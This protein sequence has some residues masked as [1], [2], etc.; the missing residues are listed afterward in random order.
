MNPIVP[1]DP[2]GIEPAASAGWSDSLARLVTGAALD[3][4]WWAYLRLLGLLLP[5]AVIGWVVL[6]ITAKAG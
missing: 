6:S 2:P 1:L 5:I 4:S 3:W